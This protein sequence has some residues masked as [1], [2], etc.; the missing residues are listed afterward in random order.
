[1]VNLNLSTKRIRPKHMSIFFVVRIWLVY[2]KNISVICF[3]NNENY[4]FFWI[5][6]ATKR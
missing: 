1:L 3:T 5:T 4:N 6:T 2:E